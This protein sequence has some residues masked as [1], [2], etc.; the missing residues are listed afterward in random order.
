[1]GLS[2]ELIPPQVF[3][4]TL[5]LASIKKSESVT[6]ILVTGGSEDSINYIKFLKV[7]LFSLALW[8]YVSHDNPPPPA[9]ENGVDTCFALPFCS[10]TW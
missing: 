9:V 2:Q 8:I 7:L 1:M 5:I 3:L 6:H 10:Q 4:L